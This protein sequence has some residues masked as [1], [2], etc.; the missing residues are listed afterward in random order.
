[1]AQLRDDLTVV[2]VGGIEQLGDAGTGTSAAEMMMIVMIMLGKVREE[3]MMQLNNEDRLLTVKF[4]ANLEYSQPVFLFL[5]IIASEL[6]SP[7]LC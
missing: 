2:V 6:L 7:R 1:V 5:P 3:V 4:N